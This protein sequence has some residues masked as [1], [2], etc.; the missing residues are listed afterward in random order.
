[1]I[2]LLFTVILFFNINGALDSSHE[3]FI[4]ITEIT[5]N[6]EKNRVEIISRLFFDDLEE[7]FKERY[8]SELTLEPNN[9]SENIDFIIE[10]YFE[11]KLKISVDDTY[12][13]LDYLGYKFDDD[14]INIFFK[15]DN[16]TQFE[17]IGVHNLILT[18]VFDDQQNIVHG[19]KNK[20]KRS[21]ILTK[22]DYEHVLK[23]N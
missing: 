15:I 3:Y 12:K 13:P 20:Q 1:M 11:K 22:H 23:F 17:N 9:V 5:Y 10:K 8:S 4:S 21:V 2:K 16:I 7:V 14:R 19:F 6:Q 18:D